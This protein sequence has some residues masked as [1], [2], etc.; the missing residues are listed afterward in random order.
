MPAARFFFD[1][2]SG[3]VLWTNAPEDRDPAGYAA[4]LQTLPVSAALRDELARLAAAYD[5]SLNQDYPPDPG[6]W[7]EPQCREFNDAAGQAVRR[8][9]EE[10]GPAWPIQNRFQELHEDPDL[11]RYLADPAGFTRARDDAS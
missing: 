11:D 2:G 9:R 5:T 3:T 6:P 7:R 10:L 1:A 8:L 4:D